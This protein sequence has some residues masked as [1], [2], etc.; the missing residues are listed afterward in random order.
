MPDQDRPDL[1]PKL[2]S[3]IYGVEVGDDR[4]DFCGSSRLLWFMLHAQSIV[5]GMMTSWEDTFISITVYNLAE[6][7]SMIPTNRLQSFDYARKNDFNNLGYIDVA[8]IRIVE[9][10]TKQIMDHSSTSPGKFS[11]MAGKLRTPRSGLAKELIHVANWLQDGMLRSYM[12][13]EPKYLP[14]NL[15]GSNCE[16]SFGNWVNQFLYLKTYKHGTYERITATA[17]NEARRCLTDMDRD[18]PVK[19]DLINTL[20]RKQEYLHGTYKN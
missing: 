18:I 8:P 16:A 6:V 13:K 14:T 2:P 15:G 19:S 17:I 1:D 20:R 10:V 12:A 3:F 11:M 7:T 9:D 4:A 5:L